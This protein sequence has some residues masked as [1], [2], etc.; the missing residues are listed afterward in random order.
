M[1]RKAVSEYEDLLRAKRDQSGQIADSKSRSPHLIRAVAATA[2]AA[3]A[4]GA[5]F[6]WSQSSLSSSQP[7]ANVGGTAIRSAAEPYKTGPGIPLRPVASA[8]SVTADSSTS[9]PQA[10][11]AP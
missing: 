7:Y 8:A 3:A 10:R 5:I 4:A 6:A 2:L 9:H 1:V 11:E